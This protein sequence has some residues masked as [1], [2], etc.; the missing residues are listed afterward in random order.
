M[1]GT[2][3][4][5][6]IS[7][8]TVMYLFSRFLFS[9]AVEPTPPEPEDTGP[10]WCSSRARRTA[11][12]FF[13]TVLICCTWVGVTHLLKWAYKVPGATY[14]PPHWMNGSSW[15]TPVNG[16][17]STVPF[18]AP[19]MA[20]WFFTACNCLFFPVYLCLRRKEVHKNNTDIE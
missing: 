19:F 17:S 20:T 13:L 8:R 4:L 7:G 15:A 16:S 12:G 10:G 1:P 6:C 5:I 2:T 3:I 11:I 14:H 18:R 9:F